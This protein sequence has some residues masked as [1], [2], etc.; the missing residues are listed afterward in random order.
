M[1]PTIN[2]EDSVN[3]TEITNPDYNDTLELES[4]EPITYPN[5]DNIPDLTTSDIT[6]N[7]PVPTDNDYDDMQELEDA[8]SDYQINITHTTM[9]TPVSTDHDYNDMPELEEPEDYQI[10][11]THTTINNIID[12]GNYPQHLQYL[13]TTD[14][15]WFIDNEILLYIESVVIP[16]LLQYEYNKTSY[17][18]AMIDFLYE[19]TYDKEAIFYNIGC[20]KTMYEDGDDIENDMNIVRRYILL[21]ERNRAYISIQSPS[22]NQL[23]NVFSSM[24]QRIE[25]ELEE[26]SQEDV[27]LII[28]PEKLNDIPIFKYS[29][30]K[31]EVNSNC[32]C[33]SE[34]FEDST[35]VKKVLCGHLFHPACIDKWLSEC[36]YKCPNCRQPAGEYTTD[37]DNT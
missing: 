4:S 24:V 27:K 35:M 11:I 9:N 34:D 2:N 25:S 8:S 21:L 13:A 26:Q 20:Y 30:I 17:Y 28:S 23:I 16:H 10:N 1:D 31:S 36:S 18:H 5:Y 32:S 29:E 15:L 12:S 33:C 19:S 3:L 37:I 22:F 14:Y 7:T 6:M